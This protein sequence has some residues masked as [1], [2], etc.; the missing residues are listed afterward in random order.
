MGKSIKDRGE[1]VKGDEIET[2]QRDR[3][4]ETEGGG[5]GERERIAMLFGEGWG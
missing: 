2:E 5:G 4:T 3:E 1:I